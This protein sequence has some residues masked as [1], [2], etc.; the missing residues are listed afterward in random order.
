MPPLAGERV[1]QQAR[2]LDGM[3]ELR[4]DPPE[5]FVAGT[6][7]PPG[8]RTFYLQARG[9]GRVTSVAL[10]KQQVA[11]LAERMDQLLDEVV[12][13]TRGA[14]TVPATAP[15]EL[16][17]SDPLDTPVEEEFR[18]ASL[19]LS[20]DSA[21]ERVVVA[22][23]SVDP[24]ADDGDDVDDAD[25]ADDAAGPAA[26]GLADVHPEPVLLT[27][28]ITGAMAREFARRAMVVVAAG[29]PLCPFCALPLDPAG[30]VCPRA[31]GYRRR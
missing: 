12:R 25:D 2:R 4:Y 10:E 13:R 17:D 20:W 22:A 21:D 24:D 28:R 1:A 23:G 11:L 6:V 26:P 18:V 31:N 8:E 27:V 14:T 15:V 29:R 3:P 19:T 9:G 5:R 30:H 16:A 7:G